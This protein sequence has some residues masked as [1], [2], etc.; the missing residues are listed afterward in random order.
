MPATTMSG[1]FAAPTLR[2][3]R[4][5]EAPAA[6]F[7]KPDGL[8]LCLACWK[9]WI[10]GD[11]DN[12]LGI[13]TSRGMVGEGAARTDIYEAQQEADER[14]G[15]AT[16]AMINSLPRIQAWA[17]YRSCS[18]ASVW[19]FPNANFLEVATEAKAQL[20]EKLKRNVCTATLF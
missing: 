14:I 7:V 17:I 15:A 18:I 10:S 16:D 13:K 2:R 3:V 19:K 20:I 11:P 6:A 8:D 1:P 12:D 4:R 5:A 9:E